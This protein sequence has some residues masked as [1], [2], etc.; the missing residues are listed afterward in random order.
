M[1]AIPAFACASLLV[2]LPALADTVDGKWVGSLDTPNG[3]VD[4]NYTFSAKG[5]M[6]T[7]FTTSPDGMSI[8]IKDGKIKGNKLSFSLTLDFGQ[9]PV[10]FNYT[11]EVSPA[12][13]KLHTDFMGQPLDFA[14]KKS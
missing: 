14:L 6:L 1:R 9:G 2:A 4:V 5:E 7:G 10:T 12:Q 13:L 11:G 3:P 8:P